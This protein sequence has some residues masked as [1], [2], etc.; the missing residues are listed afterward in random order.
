MDYAEKARAL[1]REGCGAVSG[2]LFLLNMKYGYNDPKDQQAKKDLYRKVQA[3][4]AAFAEANGSLI[5]RELLRGQAGQGGDPE[6][7]SEDYYK[8]RPC[9][10]LVGCA[11]GI[12]ARMLAAPDRPE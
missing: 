6:P 5:C 12:A 7:R 8:K 3:A 1:F 9:V 11:A 10:E 2:I 4:G